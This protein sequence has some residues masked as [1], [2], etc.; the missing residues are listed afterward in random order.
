MIFD[1]NTF[2][3][4]QRISLTPGRIC[5]CMFVL[6][7]SQSNDKHRFII[8]HTF[9]HDF[10]FRRKYTFDETFVS[11]WFMNLFGFIFLLSEYLETNGFLC[12]TINRQ[13]YLPD[14]IVYIVSISSNSDVLSLFVCLC[15][16]C[17]FIEVIKQANCPITK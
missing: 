1:I 8:W 12:F 16:F 10:F 5:Y 2:L 13:F 7:L 14:P 6:R 17:L 3:I 4:T 15:V 11:D 9:W